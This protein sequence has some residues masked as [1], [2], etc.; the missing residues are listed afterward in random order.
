MVKMLCVIF[1]SVSLFVFC[2]Q[3]LNKTI[4]N[5]IPAFQEAKTSIDSMAANQIQ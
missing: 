2:M 5:E 3:G 1:I 4:I